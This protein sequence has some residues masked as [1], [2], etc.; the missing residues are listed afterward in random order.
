MIRNLEPVTQNRKKSI[1]ESIKD[2][3]QSIPDSTRRL[4]DGFRKSRKM[5]DTVISYTT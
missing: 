3:D 4:M 1:A 5:E 2:T